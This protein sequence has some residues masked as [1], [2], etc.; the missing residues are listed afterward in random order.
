MGCAEV[1]RAWFGCSSDVPKYG[2]FGG[3]AGG[4]VWGREIFCKIF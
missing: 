2:T 3:K 1:L 4:S